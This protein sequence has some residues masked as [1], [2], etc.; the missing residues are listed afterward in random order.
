MPNRIASLTRLPALTSCLLTLVLLTSPLRQPSTPARPVPPPAHAT[1]LL[2]KQER[3]LGTVK[4]PQIEKDP[5]SYR[6]QDSQFRLREPS[7][8]LTAVALRQ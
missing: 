5:S 2:A 4:R 7:P 6:G 3:R 8:C 1:V